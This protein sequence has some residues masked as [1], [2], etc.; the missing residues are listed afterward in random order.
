M[1]LNRGWSERT[2]ENGVSFAGLDPDGLYEDVLT[3]DTFQ[4]SGDWLSVWMAGN[5]SRVLVRR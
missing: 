1:I 4:A 2:V 5:S 3:G